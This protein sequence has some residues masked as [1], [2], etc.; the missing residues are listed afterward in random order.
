MTYKQV[1]VLSIV[2]LDNLIKIGSLLFM[3]RRKKNEI[4]ILKINQNFLV[5][6]DVIYNQPRN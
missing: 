3:L 5:L 1:S 2:L 4:L 6:I